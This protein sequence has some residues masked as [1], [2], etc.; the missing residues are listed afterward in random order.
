MSGSKDEYV[1]ADTGAGSNRLLIKLVSFRRRHLIDLRYWYTNGAG[2][3]RPTK[4]GLSLSAGHFGVIVETVSRFEQSIQAWLSRDGDVQD[5]LNAEDRAA[6]TDAVRARRRSIEIAAKD[7]RWGNLPDVRMG[8]LE[9][10]RTRAAFSVQHHGGEETVFLNRAHPF[11]K[12]VLDASSADEL[13][14]LLVTA[15]AAY[16]RAR[17]AVADDSDQG[18]L[19]LLEHEWA[20]RLASA[21]RSHSTPGDAA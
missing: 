8:V 6:T 10:P 14:G 15:I 4:K 18:L 3:L 5:R 13:R 2:E 7:A 12:R 1:L 11:A 20:E 9:E 16:G 21:A 17:H 19:D